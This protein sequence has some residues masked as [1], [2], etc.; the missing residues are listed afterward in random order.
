MSKKSN[1]LIVN[2][3]KS[4]NKIV[5]SAIYS[6][7]PTSAVSVISLTM[8]KSRRKFTI[9]ISAEFVVLVAE[10]NLFTVIH[11][12]LVLVLKAKKIISV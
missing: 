2:M 8:R 12:K 11:A 7:L 1:A 10:K 9:A 5:K 6:L 3:Y 4:L